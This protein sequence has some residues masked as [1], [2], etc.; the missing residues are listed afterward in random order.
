MARQSRRPKNRAGTTILSKLP[1]PAHA[2]Q[3]SIEK[4]TCSAACRATCGFAIGHRL[5]IMN[6]T[7]LHRLN[8]PATLAFYRDKLGFEITFRGPSPDDEFFGIVR[9][10]S[11]WIMFKALGGIVDGG[12]AF[13][14]RYRIDVP[15]T[16]HRSS[17]AVH[18]V[19]APD[20]DATC[21]ELQALGANIVE[22]LEKMLWGLRQFTVKDLDGNV[23]YFH[24]D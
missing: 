9:R 4:A 5:A 19:F 18:W 3:K 20:I 23:F 17:P 11:A 7:V 2:T 15:Q 6:T 1:A 21:K 12:F 10:G 24:H 14:V 16:L 13:E 22:P 8:V